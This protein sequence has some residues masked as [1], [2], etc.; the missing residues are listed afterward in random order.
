MGKAALSVQSHCTVSN[1]SKIVGR[2]AGDAVSPLDRG[3]LLP[4]M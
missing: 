2:D 3:L 1:E 4:A